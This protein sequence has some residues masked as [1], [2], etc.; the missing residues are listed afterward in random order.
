MKEIKEPRAKEEAS[1]LRKKI[2]RIADSRASIKAKNREKGRTIKAYQDRQVE[3]EQ[4]RDEWKAKCKQ[5]Q[6]ERLEADK[7][8]KE[9]ATLF[10]I[11]E[12]QL[13]ALIKEFEELK[14][15]NRR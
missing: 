3:L 7:K 14:K 6:K 11:K 13:K 4:N 12:E 5:E 1:T 9:I 15:K 8:Y 10:E 2:K